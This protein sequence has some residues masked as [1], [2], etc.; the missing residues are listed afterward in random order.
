MPLVAAGTDDTYVG[1]HPRRRH[2]GKRPQLVDRGRQHPQGRGPQRRADRGNIAGARSDP[3]HGPQRVLRGERQVI[4]ILDSDAYLERLL[5]APRPGSEN[6]L[7]FYDHRLE[8]V[9]RDPRLLFLPLDDHLAHRG[10]GVFETLKFVDNRLY[11]LD[12]H[13]ERM[14]LSSKAIFLDPP[15]RLERGAGVGAGG[16]QSRRTSPGAGPHS[17]GRGPGGFGI[18]PAECPMPSLYIVAY[19]FYPRP[20]AHYEQGVSA[21]RTSIPAKQSF[22]ARIKSTDYLPNML[23]KREALEKGCVFPVCFDDRGCLAGRL[24]GE[25]LHRGQVGLPCGAGIHQRPGRHLHHPRPGSHQRRDGPRPS[26]PSARKKSSKPGS[27][28]PWAPPS[29]P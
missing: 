20:E 22:M 14:R 23:M 15:L 28:W 7:A 16:G 6:I 26:A 10:D 12:P 4:P 27:L 5:S 29:T 1:A 19:R 17:P 18:D 2:G 11:Q 3:G 8:A 21:C 24:H 9:G 13:M 25:H